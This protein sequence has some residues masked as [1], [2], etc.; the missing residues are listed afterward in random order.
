MGAGGPAGAGAD[1]DALA[2]LGHQLAMHVVALKPPYVSRSEGASCVSN[3]CRDPICHLPSCCTLCQRSHSHTAHHAHSSGRNEACLSRCRAVVHQHQRVAGHTCERAAVECPMAC[4][5]DFGVVRVHLSC[6][7]GVRCQ[8][9]WEHGVSAYTGKY[10]ASGQVS[11]HCSPGITPCC[12]SLQAPLR[13]TSFSLSCAQCPVR[14]WM[15]SAP[16]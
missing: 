8:S 1:R 5:S 9:S 10:T 13:L 4:I 3:A 15:Q 12:R 14:R 2:E 16:S 6:R 11:S 7:H